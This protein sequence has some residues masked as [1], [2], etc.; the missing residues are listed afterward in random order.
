MNKSARND[1][2]AGVLI[3]L[4]TGL[5]ASVTGDIYVDPLDPGFSSIDFPIMVLSLLAILSVVLIARSVPQLMRDGWRLYEPGE[6]GSLLK[7]VVPMAVTG[8][9]YIA[10]I[11]MFQYPLPTLAATAAALALF[12]NG[13]W[14]RLLIVPLVATLIYYVVF[15]VVLGLYEPAGTVWAY[16]TRWFINRIRGLLWLN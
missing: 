13:G 10:L 14:G 9:A 16:E 6:A 2:F 12:G 11:R 4:V 3:L 15:Y 5:F 7:F 1:A 8:F